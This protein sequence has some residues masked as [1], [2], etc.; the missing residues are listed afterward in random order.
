MFCHVGAALTSYS[1][2][3]ND[4][5]WLLQTVTSL[6]FA[7]SQ[8]MFLYASPMVWNLLLLSLHE[9]ETLSLCKKC[10]KNIL[11]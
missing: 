11:F 5:N 9:N 3:V 7:T 1:L 8:S 10:L 2:R 4:D 6:I